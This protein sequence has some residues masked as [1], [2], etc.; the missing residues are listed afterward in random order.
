MQ[1]C[2]AEV[3]KTSGRSFAGVSKYPLPLFSIKHCTPMIRRHPRSR[4]LVS[5]TIFLSVTASSTLRLFKF[6]QLQVASESITGT[7]FR[8]C[9]L[10]TGIW[11]RIDQGSPLC[12]HGLS[13]PIY[14]ASQILPQLQGCCLPLGQKPNVQSVGQGH[15]RGWHRVQT[16]GQGRRGLRCSRDVGAPKSG[17]ER[18]E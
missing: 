11:T 2:T 5:P 3:Y 17:S 4:S 16:R 14:G 7:V 12:L 13:G 18:C 8:L 9:Q 1:Y 6:R 10:F 15:P